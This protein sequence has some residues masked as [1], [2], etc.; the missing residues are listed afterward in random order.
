VILLDIFPASLIIAMQ[1]NSIAKQQKSKDEVRA[2]ALVPH[3]YWTQRPHFYG[4]PME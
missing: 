4:R 2:C 3:V 1:Q